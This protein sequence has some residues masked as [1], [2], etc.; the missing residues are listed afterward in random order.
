MVFVVAR[1]MHPPRRP[2]S[3]RDTASRLA[4]SFALAACAACLVAARAVALTADAGP[5]FGKLP[6]VDEV[7]CAL[8][9]AESSK[10]PFHEDPPGASRLVKVLG[11]PCRVLPNEGG[12][13]VFAYRLGSGKGLE[14]GKAYVLSLE[15]PEDRSRSM[16]VLNRGCET[17][18]GFATGQAVGDVVH[19]RYV[20]SNP[21]SLEYPLS[22][23]HERWRQ[24]F[25]LHDRFAGI[26]APRG[27]GARP[28]TP[29]KGFWVIV[30]QSKAA[31]DPLSAGAAVSR[32]RLFEV[33]DV[34]KLD[35]T[36]RPPP[37]G[38]PRRHLFWREE[39]SD[40][41]IDGR[42]KPSERGVARDVDWFEYKAR[43]MRFLGMNTYCKDLLEFGH[44][45]G[46]DSAVYGGNSWVN[47]SASPDRWRE[48][49]EMVRRYGFDVLPYY[50]YA[51]SVGGKSL[52]CQKRAKTLGGGEAYTH[53]WWSEK[54]NADVTDPDTLADAKK[55]LDATI[56][57]HKD[58]AGFVGA[59]F[60]TR[61]SHIPIG[62]GERSLALFAREI[63]L[64]SAVT[65]EDLRR[66]RALLGK[67][68]DWWFLKR[69]AFLLALRDY[70]R[71]RVGPEAIV[72]FTAD[73]SEPG[74]SSA[75]GAVVT[76][77]LAAWNALKGRTG[78]EKL[79]VRAFE[80]FA[81]SDRH[82]AALV[83]PVPTW[84]KWEWQHSC[85]QAD[86]A[87]YR[88][89]DGALMTYTFNRACTV[90]SAKAFET[91]RTR[92]GLAAIRH[93]CLNENE[94]EKK[95]GYFVSDVE[96]AGPHCMMAES[97]A[98]AG[99]DPRYIGYLASNSFQ[100]GF[101]EYARA[102]NAAFLA[103]PALPSKVLEDASSDP[104]VVVR[105]IP[106]ERHGTYFAVVNTGLRAKGGVRL[107]LPGTGSVTDAATGFTLRRLGL[108]VRLDMGPCELKALSVK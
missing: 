93:Y 33:P 15:Y 27:K 7:D 68:Y 40:G 3:A 88:G 75:R 6:L 22:G 77:D 43:L 55:V 10:H 28:D 90:G 106:T 24:M 60:R 5:P 65:R 2:R 101:P 86:P 64:G 102:F 9:G 8:E 69:K 92:S 96:R 79:K 103:L 51:G 57:R 25:H 98:V 61:P 32:I 80:E 45:Q 20:S 59:W 35:L 58:E 67:Y 52:G 49:L 81:R 87:N 31:N 97:R 95:V 105:A 18:L 83:S 39:M 74:R 63:G 23:R 30:A 108:S 37:E 34:T 11:Q 38:L 19:G 84:G 4:P 16:F 99:G 47:Q 44:N 17:N 1:M 78:H 89:E 36:L 91:F 48:I 29:E 104:E 50:E 66:D 76:D 85:P 41:V 13:K 26:K 72:M 94:M 100:R 53:I 46:W 71:E 54:A 14:A 42:A 70:L 56:V 73:T 21:E 107:A 82:L 12:A 62:F